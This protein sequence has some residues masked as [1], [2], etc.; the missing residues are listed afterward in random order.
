MKLIESA[1]THTNKEFIKKAETVHK[2]ENNEPLF[3]YSKT[4]YIGS[5]YPVTIICKKCGNEFS[6]RASHHLNGTGCKKCANE[7]MRIRR[8]SNTENFINKAKIIHSDKYNYDKVIYVNNLEKVKLKCNKCD[9]EFLQTPQSHLNGNGCPICARKNHSLFM[10]K[11]RETFIEESEIIHR[12]NNGDTLYDY[13]NVDYKG[14]KIPVIIR[15]KKC[16]HDFLQKPKHHLYDSGCQNCNKSRGEKYILNR[17]K[18]NN[19]KFETQKRFEECRNKIH[20]PFDFYL[21]DFNICIEYDGIIHYEIRNNLGGF[22]R[23]VQQKIND[24]IKNKFCIDNNIKLFRIKYSDN[25]KESFQTIID[26]IKNKFKNE[27]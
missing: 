16:G 1:K 2:D 4:N 3:D 14:Y 13:S 24:R 7:K 18:Q 5:K 15:C 8:L 11:S 27:I 17:L 25:I 26:Y 6:Q 23:L 22:E 20:L 9:Y 12:D 21:P 10:K 19:I